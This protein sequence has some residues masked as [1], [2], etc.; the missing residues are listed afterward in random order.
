LLISFLGTRIVAEENVAFEQNGSEVKH[1]EK[2][3]L[4][5][6]NRTGGSSPSDF[7]NEKKRGS[8]AP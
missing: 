3:M 2:E 1:E 4:R 6:Q 5:K 7:D 8:Y